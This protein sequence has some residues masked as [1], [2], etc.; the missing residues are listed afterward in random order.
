MIVKRNLSVRRVAAYIS[1]PMAWVAAW[2]VA[3]P[4]MSLVVD[5][6]RLVAPF[7][8]AG[9]IGAALAIFIAFRNN[10]AFGRW[11]EGRA[12][13]QSIL[14]AS[15]AITRQVIASTDNALAMG[16]I[17]RSTA[18]RYRRE[19]TSLLST[20]ARSVAAPFRPSLGAT[21][22]PPTM[23]TVELGVL[24]KRGIRD[25]ALGQFDP[26]ALEPQL[27]ALNNAQGTIERIASTP[28]LRQYDFFTRRFVELFAVLAP[29]AIIGLVPDRVWWTVPLSIAVSG[30]FVIM[31]VTGAANDE[32]FS[33][34]VTDVPI[35]A[36]CA[37]VD[38]DLAVLLGAPN[39]PPLAQPV[40]GYLW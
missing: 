2:S 28:T 22:A 34:M 19:T 3:V 30:V 36:V 18:E 17:D 26:I 24:I 6:D 16:E 4:A 29:F 1:R 10:S 27:A 7:A 37:E 14:V 12:A 11:M 33:G 21:S 35:E 31:A 8:P 13:W 23:V 5:D 40:D 20:F 9:A 38:H 32:P 15:R 25:G 39:P